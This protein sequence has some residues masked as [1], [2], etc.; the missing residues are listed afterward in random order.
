MSSHE[1]SEWSIDDSTGFSD[2]HG[3]LVAFNLVSSHTKT[4]RAGCSLQGSKNNGS[5]ARR[6]LPCGQSASD[7]IV[8][9]IRQRHHSVF[10]F[11]EPAH[12]GYLITIHELDS[13]STTKPDPARVSARQAAATAPS[14]L[15]DRGERTLWSSIVMRPRRVPT[16]PAA[17]FCLKRLPL[18]GQWGC[19]L[20]FK[21]RD[22]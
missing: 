9:C 14:T 2:R 3:G 11:V 12:S 4:A 1:L 20:K 22:S 18:V 8:V 6:T 10:L 19:N 17:G 15:T 5:F 16:E 7:K 13:I 21:R